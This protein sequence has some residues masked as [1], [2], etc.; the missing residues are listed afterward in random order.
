MFSNS[1][2]LPMYILSHVVLETGKGTRQT[3]QVDIWAFFFIWWCGC[4][5]WRDVWTST[6][7]SQAPPLLLCSTHAHL[8]THAHAHA[9]AGPERKEDI[10]LVNS[11]RTMTNRRRKNIIACASR[12]PRINN[13]RC[14]RV[15]ATCTGQNIPSFPLW[16]ESNTY[17]AADQRTLVVWHIIYLCSS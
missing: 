3:E 15:A 16:R 14:Q 8:H 17:C 13:A 11:E 10:R 4:M 1:Y 6:C 5:W 7:C 9:R 12:P 2:L